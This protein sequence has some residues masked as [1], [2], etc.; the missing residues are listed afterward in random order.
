MTLSQRKYALDLLQEVGLFGC[1]PVQTPM[2]ANTD[3]Q[4]ESGPLLEDATHYRNW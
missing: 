4:D 3:L 1:K 2:N